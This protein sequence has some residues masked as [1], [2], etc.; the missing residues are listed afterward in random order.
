MVL[1]DRFSGPHTAVDILRRG[2]EPLRSQFSTGYGMVLRLLRHRSLDSAR[3]FVQRSF[4]NYLG[5]PS[6]QCPCIAD[7]T[8][9]VSFRK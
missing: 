1:H 3:D 8:A 9:G 4:Y 5:E 2:P 6:A 7:I